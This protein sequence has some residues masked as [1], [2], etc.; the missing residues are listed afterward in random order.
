MVCNPENQ[1]FLRYMHKYYFT[2]YFSNLKF[3][4]RS[5]RQFALIYSA[6]ILLILILTERLRFFDAF[7]GIIFFP[8]IILRQFLKD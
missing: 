4:K 5:F 3:S 7:R 1:P 6:C 8:S 2:I